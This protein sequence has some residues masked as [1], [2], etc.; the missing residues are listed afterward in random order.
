MKHASSL[1][2]LLGELAGVEVEFRRSDETL[3][4]AIVRTPDGRRLIFVE[5]TYRE[6]VGFILDPSEAELQIAREGDLSRLWNSERRVL[7]QGIV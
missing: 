2:E 3:A 1:I 5:R 6:G 7:L 4:T